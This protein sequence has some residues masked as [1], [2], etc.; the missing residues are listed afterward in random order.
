MT[1]SPKPVRFPSR[2]Q[3]F[4]RENHA[5]IQSNESLDE[6][7][8]NPAPKSRKIETLIQHAQTIVRHLA[9]QFTARQ[10]QIENGVPH[11]RQTGKGNVVELVDPLFVQGLTR[12]GRVV[13]KKEL[14]SHKEHILVK[15]EQD[16]V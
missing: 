4:D 8:K 13:A 14:D 16:E 11:D 2:Q 9:N 1:A 5:Q 10:F 3:S 12:E 15:V 6:P 7:V